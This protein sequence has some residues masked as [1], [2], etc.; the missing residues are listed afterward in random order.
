MRHTEITGF[1][2]HSGTSRDFDHLMGRIGVSGLST[3]VVTSF[4][5][6]RP[7]REMTADAP[8]RAMHPAT[9]RFH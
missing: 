9:L 6:T 5:M 1:D 7:A 2:L 8:Q 3:H 4:I